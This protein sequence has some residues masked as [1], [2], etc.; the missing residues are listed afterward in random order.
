MLY[1]G[2]EAGMWGA[3][4]PCD[5]QPM[6]WDDV[7]YQPERAGILGPVPKRVRRPDHALHAFVKKALA[8]RHAEP[9]LRRGDF[10]WLSTGH[11]R[12]MA[13]ER[14]LDGRRIQ[15]YFNA[16]DETRLAKPVPGAVDL[17]TGRR[18]EVGPLNIP[19][20]SWRVV[21]RA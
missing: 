16:S 17:W 20:R 12:L 2:T 15:A 7:A 1:Y 3:N 21:A 13:F 6:V 11:D 14:A 10:R 9:A 4:D 8:L 19:A 5:R 18:A